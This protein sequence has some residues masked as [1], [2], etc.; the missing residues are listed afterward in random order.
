MLSYASQLVAAHHVA[1]LSRLLK[2]LADLCSYR[3]GQQA[4]FSK[5]LR[6]RVYTCPTGCPLGAMRLHTQGSPD[7]QIKVVTL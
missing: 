6:G 4:A 2:L 1:A 3:S 5:R 7:G